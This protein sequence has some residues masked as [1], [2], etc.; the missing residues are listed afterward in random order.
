ACRRRAM[1]GRA[2]GAG[3]VPG[4]LRSFRRLALDLCRDLER[5][6]YDATRLWPAEN[7]EAERIVDV[8]G[9]AATVDAVD[10]G[11]DE[12]AAGCQWVLKFGADPEAL[13]GRDRPRA[14]GVFDPRTELEY[15]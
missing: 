5:Q 14:V 7:D 8:E 6:Q 3:S 12:V 4:S 1:T 11:M 2:P 13:P 10:P 15:A 9:D